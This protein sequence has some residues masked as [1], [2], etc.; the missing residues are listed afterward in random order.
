MPTTDPS[1]T[2]LNPVVATHLWKQGRNAWNSWVEENPTSPISFREIAFHTHTDQP[3]I[4]FSGFRFPNAPICFDKASFGDKPVSFMGA[5]FG[6]GEVTFNEAQF[7]NGDVSFEKALFGNGKVSFSKTY[8]GRGSLSF[9]EAHFG[10]GDVSFDGVRCGS[11]F[12][13][14]AGAQFGH[15]YVSFDD[16]QFGDGNVSFTKARFGEGDVSF[17][18]VRF[19]EGDVFFIEAQFG[20]GDVSFEEAQFGNGKISF[21]GAQFG[22]GYVFFAATKF[23]DGVSFTKARFGEGDVSFYRAQFGNGHVSFYGA[24]F[25]DGNISFEKAQFGDVS[26]SFEQ[27]HIKGN[28]QFESIQLRSCSHFSFHGSQFEGSLILH[29]IA[30]ECVIDLRNTKLSRPIDL[31]NVKTKFISERYFGLFHRAKHPNDSTC[32]RRLKK[33]AKEADDHDSALQFFAGE[34]RAG[35]WHDVKGAELLFYYLY[36]LLSN[37]GR[38]IS[39][40]LV[41]LFATWSGFSYLYWN[42]QTEWNPSPASAGLLSMGHS[43]PFYLGSRDTISHSLTALYGENIPAWIHVAAVGQSVIS[44]IF[45]FLIALALRNL[46]RS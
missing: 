38:S 19:G 7:G 24:Q 43:I 22:N 3:S 30:I 33:L 18:G 16:A 34:K 32:Y 1:R 46:S 12:I 40:P 5:I 11:G 45:L 8:F 23:G 28:F 31:D 35:Y 42:A 27:M 26:L 2:P 39:R 36:D 10:N 6:D 25:G 20:D 14:F 13:S 37:Y 44:G 41:G 9:T 21:T 29:Q 4:D 15:G 17:T